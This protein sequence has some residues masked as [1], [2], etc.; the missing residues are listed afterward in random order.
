MKSDSSK[1]PALTTWKKT[2]VTT[3][4]LAVSEHPIAWVV[5]VHMTPRL[6]LKGVPLMG[7]STRQ[8]R[9]CYWLSCAFKLDDWLSLD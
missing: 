3:G 8:P 2:F 9:R 7:G 4:D 1:V 6:R 5:G